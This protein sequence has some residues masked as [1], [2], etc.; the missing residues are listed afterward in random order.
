M[1]GDEYYIMHFERLLKHKSINAVVQY[2]QNY[3]QL[4]CGRELTD[5]DENFFTPQNLGS[6]AFDCE[7]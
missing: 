7:K 3:F 1:L 4:S 2:C 5:P 6:E